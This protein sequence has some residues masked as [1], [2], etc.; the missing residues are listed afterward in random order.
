MGKGTIVSEQ[1]EGE[2]VITPVFDTVRLEAVKPKL[3]A[4]RA[5][6]ITAISETDTLITELEVIQR[7]EVAFLDE[8]IDTANLN[9]SS[10]EE[11]IRLFKK[12]LDEQTAAI[13]EANQLLADAKLLKTKLEIERAALDVEIIKIDS[14]ILKYVTPGNVTAWCSNFSLGLTGDVGTIELEDETNS[15]NDQSL[16]IAVDG[17][18]DT[19]INQPIESSEQWAIAYNLIA[20]NG[21]QRW[22]PRYRQGKITSVDKILNVCNITFQDEGENSS[23]IGEHNVRYNIYQTPNLVDV[24]IIYPPCD[25]QVFEFGDQVVVSFNGLWEEPTVTGFIDN[26]KSCGFEFILSVV[27]IPSLNTDLSVRVNSTAAD[28]LDVSSIVVGTTGNIGWTNGTRRFT[29]EGPRERSFGPEHLIFSTNDLDPIPGG[30]LLDAILI[31]LITPANNLTLAY[32]VEWNTAVYEKGVGILNPPVGKVITGVGINLDFILITVFELTVSNR[33]KDSLYLWNTDHWVLLFEHTYDDTLYYVLPRISPSFFKRDGTKAVLHNSRILK[34]EAS[35]RLSQ[36]EESSR[37]SSRFIEVEISQMNIDLTLFDTM[38]ELGHV[39]SVSPVV[40]SKPI[41]EGTRTNVGQYGNVF[42]P[43]PPDPIDNGLRTEHIMTGMSYSLCADW[44]YNPLTMLDTLNIFKIDVPSYTDVFDL[45]VFGSRILG[46]VGAGE[47][48]T[49]TF[50]TLLSHDA[51]I[52]TTNGFIKI[53]TTIDIN[54][55][56]TGHHTS[57]PADPDPVWTHTLNKVSSFD[58]ITLAYLDLRTDS[59]VYTEDEYTGTLT[60]D[61]EG[62]FKVNPNTETEV[63]TGAIT[64]HENKPVSIKGV[65]DNLS[66]L[67][68]IQAPNFDY[69]GLNRGTLTNPA[70][71]K[72]FIPPRIFS[73]VEE[74]DFVF[75]DDRVIPVA[76]Q[77]N[78]FHSIHQHAFLQPGFDFTTA[79]IDMRNP[80][81]L[82]SSNTFANSGVGG[83]TVIAVRNSDNVPFIAYTS[84]SSLSTDGISL[85]ETALGIT[86]AL[87]TDMRNN[88]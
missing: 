12:L 37:I 80:V 22:A 67:T 1:G 17:T 47:F 39:V 48:R 77:E 65:S 49:H 81:S 23:I 54:D 63:T 83:D 19:K 84:D 5:A 32:D 72:Y 73:T 52:T 86:I 30:R 21:F 51:T 88:S 64:I 70:F 15:P 38:T 79:N 59:I 41:I 46:D 55:S 7:Q 74:I 16:I 66:I 69:S 10:E 61:G 87:V 35:S 62:F 44:H 6:V 27:E 24:P 71:Y 58:R 18:A 82:G 45:T 57:D 42:A 43:P 40:I 78:I 28:T 9:S 31:D 13:I 76:S 85:I 75:F 36:N 33:N 68:D 56:H 3:I 20:L 2:Y 26:P 50:T 53:I 29:F 60:A 11:F 25:A 8:E 14:A 34:T 4:R